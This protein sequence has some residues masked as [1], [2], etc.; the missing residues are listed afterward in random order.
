LVPYIE[1]ILGKYQCHFTRG[2]A[3]VDR[4]FIMKL[5]TEKTFEFGIH[6]NLF[7]DFKQAD[8]LARKCQY[9]ILKE[10]RIL[11]KL[12]NPVRMALTDSN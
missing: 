6:F 11:M 12:V 1:E 5:V 2:H 8:T 7:T 10:F 3:T 9:E 4:M